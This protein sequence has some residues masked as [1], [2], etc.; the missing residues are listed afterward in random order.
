MN[1]YQIEQLEALRMIRL[2]CVFITAPD[3]CKLKENG[4]RHELPLVSA[5]GPC[6]SLTPYCLINWIGSRGSRV[7]GFESQEKRLKNKRIKG[8]SLDK[9]A[10]PFGPGLTSSFLLG[11]KANIKLTWEFKT[12]HPPYN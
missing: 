1:D 6:S 7:Q 8:K 9:N 5:C 11:K 2:L 12:F 3:Y 10:E 4:N